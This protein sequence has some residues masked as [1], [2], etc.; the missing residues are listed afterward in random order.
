MATMREIAQSAGVS[1]KTVSRVYND[2]PHVRPELRERVRKALADHDYVP[3]ELAQTFRSGRGRVVGVAVPSLVDPFFAAIVEAVGIEAQ[4]RGYGTLVTSTGFDPADEQL[5]VASLLER[6]LSGLIIAP[7]SLDQSFLSGALPTVLVDQPAVGIEL[8][9]FVHDDH[10]GAG[11][12]I[13]HLLNHGLRRV[14]FLGRSPGLSTMRDRLAGYRD[15]LTQAGITVDMNLVEAD[16]DPSGDGASAYEL[17]RARGMDALFAADP[18]STI[19]CLPALQKDPAP[20]VGFGDFPLAE[21]L[22]PAVTVIDQSPQTMG[23]NAC[24]HLFSLISAGTRT[25]AGSASLVRLPV[26]LIERKSCLRRARP[27]T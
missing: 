19:S 24:K 21:L 9:A 14:G 8:D 6:R 1:L 10:T 26:T 2:D 20:L 7:V 25:L 11:L 15:A 12:A 3:N 22:T 13:R 4:R 17:L 23:H 27:T 16:I 5:A 18:R